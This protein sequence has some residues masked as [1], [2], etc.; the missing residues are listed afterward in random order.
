[1]SVF[2]IDQNQKTL[3]ILRDSLHYNRYTERIPV[4]QI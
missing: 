2:L 4:G 1:M 3:D